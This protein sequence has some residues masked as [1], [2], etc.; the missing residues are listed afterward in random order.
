MA[1][2]LSPALRDKTLDGVERPTLLV[3]LDSDILNQ[4]PLLGGTTM[5][6]HETTNIEYVAEVGLG[7]VWTLVEDIRRSTNGWLR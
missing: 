4:N 1:P 6:A 7:V 2:S 3:H 5:N